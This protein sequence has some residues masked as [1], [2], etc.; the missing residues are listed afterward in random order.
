MPTGI[1]VGVDMVSLARTEF[2]NSFEGF[3]VSVDVDM[4]R[5]YP[6]VEFGSSAREYAA[7]SGSTYSNEGNFWRAGI[8]VNFL[9][10]DPDKNM[11]FLGARYARSSYSEKA[12][13][14]VTDPLWG[15]FNDSFENSGLSSGW[16]ELTAGMRIKV[17]KIFW[18]GYTARFKFALSKD[19]NLPLL[20]TDVP[21]YGATDRPTTWGFS[22]YALVKIPV[23]KQK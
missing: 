17:W 22:Y 3:E 11:F 8:D 19:D 10:K 16:A 4:Y 7:A 15:T 20:T 5:Y 2:V 9:T 23:R 1:R 14:I 18:L 6:T 12:T 13:I 21:G